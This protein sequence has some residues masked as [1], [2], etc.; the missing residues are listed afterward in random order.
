MHIA[1]QQVSSAAESP[2]GDSEDLNLLNWKFRSSITSVKKKITLLERI[3]K[4]IV[5]LG[6]RAEDDG[7]M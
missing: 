5:N 6:F 7:F 1:D 3:K 4:N 2:K